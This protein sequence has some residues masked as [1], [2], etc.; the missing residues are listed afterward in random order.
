[1][2]AAGATVN[3]GDSGTVKSFADSSGG[4]RQIG[5]QEGKR[6]IRTRAGASAGGRRDSAP[7]CRPT[8]T[9]PRFYRPC[10]G[11][12]G[13]RCRPRGGD[14]ATQKTGGALVATRSAD[15][16]RVARFRGPRPQR[17]ARRV[18]RNGHQRVAGRNARQ[19]MNA[20]EFITS[21]HRQAA[22]AI[23][24]GL[25]VTDPTRPVR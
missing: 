8:P 5:E 24:A 14:H 21:D 17:L 11:A 19:P 13:G 4:Q 3:M 9:N 7:A 1:M 22:C 23:G 12:A 6:I 2:A 20:R 18:E 25:S 10:T 16:D 15:S